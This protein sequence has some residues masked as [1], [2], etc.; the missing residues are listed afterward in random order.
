MHIDEAAATLIVRA[1]STLNNLINGTATV[2]VTDTPVP[3]VTSVTVSPNPVTVN[4]GGNQTFTATVTGTNNPPETV[5]WEVTGGGVGTSINA[6]NGLL[7]VAIGETATSL[8][9]R[10][11]STFNTAVSGTAAVTVTLPPPLTVDMFRV[12]AGSVNTPTSGMGG[13]ITISEAERFYIGRFQVTQALWQEVMT[14]NPNGIS[15]TPSWFRVGGGGAAQ[16][17]GLPTYNFP[18]EQVSWFDALVFSNRLSIR[19]GRT[20]VY[21]I[22]G[23][24]NPDTW[25][26]VPTSNAH[27][28]FAAWGAVAIVSGNGYR[29]PTSAQWEFAARAGTPTDFHNGVNFVNDA[30]T[31]PLVAPIAWID[32]NSGGRTHQVGTRAANAWGLHDMHGNVWEWC[33][34]DAVVVASRVVRGACWFTNANSSRSSHWASSNLWGRLDTIGFR[35]VRP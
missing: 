33:W 22:N 4:R 31:S 13:V 10:A 35:L 25:G 2:T 34:D 27:A 5:T 24:T 29:L 26:Q 6:T 16:V 32:H 18:V 17:A 19:N 12:P 14:G 8:T 7:T 21:S 9:V 1:T 23:S 11:T 28:S 30:T 3:T 15:A 20:P